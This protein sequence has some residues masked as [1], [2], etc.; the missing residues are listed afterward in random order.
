MVIELHSLLAL[1]AGIGILIFPKILNYIIAAYF[2]V[3]G[4]TGIFDL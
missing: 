4:L 1:A 2:I 3:L